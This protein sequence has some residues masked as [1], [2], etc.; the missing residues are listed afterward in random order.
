MH[1]AGTVNG[2]RRNQQHRVLGDLRCGDVAE[3][4]SGGSVRLHQQRLQRIRRYRR[5]SK[6]RLPI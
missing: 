3:S 4:Y 2:G 6:V 5:D 1:A